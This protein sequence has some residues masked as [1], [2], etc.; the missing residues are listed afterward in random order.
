MNG[1][2]NEILLLLKKFNIIKTHFNTF[3]KAAH[4]SVNSSKIE[5]PCSSHQLQ[6]EESARADEAPFPMWLS[7]LEVQ[8][9]A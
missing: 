8:N 5:V 2:N 4:N 7:E 9:V 3:L 6:F 1:I